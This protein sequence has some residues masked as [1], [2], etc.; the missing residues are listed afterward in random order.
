MAALPCRLL[1]LAYVGS[2]GLQGR[3]APLLLREA[4]AVA[5]C[6][7]PLALSRLLGMQAYTR[8]AA[9]ALGAC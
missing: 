6:L 4:A 9:W 3:A 8:W 1:R 2:E 7:L 5:F